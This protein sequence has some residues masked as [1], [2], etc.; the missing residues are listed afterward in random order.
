LVYCLSATRNLFGEQNLP[1]TS[2]IAKLQHWQ[3]L[4]TT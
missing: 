2:I 4:K 1:H 3:H